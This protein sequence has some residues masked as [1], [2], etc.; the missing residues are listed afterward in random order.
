MRKITLII[1][2]LVS[3]FFILNLPVRQ[4]GSSFA[5]AATPAE[6]ALGQLNAAAGD[7]GAGIAGSGPKD[8]RVLAANI[9][10]MAL[11]VLGTIFLVLTVY[12]GFLWMTA[13]G[14]EEKITKAKDI[15]KAS[16]IGLLIIL[17][18]YAITSFVI[19]NLVGAIT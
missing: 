11:G 12:A 16:I 6:D 19:S 4:A 3:S 2:F 15:L 10:K 9:I 14:E 18:A 5:L 17:T 8:P 13:S 7:S 1:F